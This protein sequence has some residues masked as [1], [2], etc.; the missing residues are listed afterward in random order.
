[1]T[2]GSTAIWVKS[3]VIVATVLILV[4]LALRQITASKDTSL[5]NAP[6]ALGSSSSRI[7][8]SR[9]SG[10][11]AKAVANAA[12]SI[13]LSWYSPAQTE[14]NNL[15][16]VINGTGVWGFI[17]NTSDT[18]VEKYGQYNWCHMPHVRKTE[19]VKLP[20]EYELKYVEL[21][22]RHHKRT[23]YAKNSFPVESYKWDCDD[24][25]NFYYEEFS[26][27]RNKPGKM[28]WKVY[29]SPANPFVPA[30]FLGTCHF[31]QITAQGLDDSWLHGADLYGVY[32]DVLGFL[33]A[34]DTVNSAEWHSKVKYRVTKNP[35]TSH[36]AGM[37]VNG[38]WATT[39][40]VP[41]II[42][43]PGVDSLE[44]EYPC[45][46]G[47]DLHFGIKSPSNPVWAQHLAAADPLYTI[48]DDI[49]GFP[50][51]DEVVHTLMDCYYDNLSARQCH[52]K[53]LP[54]KLVDGVNST[55]CVT[56]DVAD[57]VY[58]LGHWEYSELYRGSR[59][60]FVSNIARFGVWLAELAAHLRA[61]VNGE[62]E[63]L[64]FHNV[65]NDCSV[66]SILSILQVDHMVWPGMGAEVLFELYEK[67]SKAGDPRAPDAGAEESGWYVRV[68]W[69]GQVLKSSSPQFG[70]MNMV[71]VEKLLAYLD[72]LVGENASLI[73][74]KCDN[75]VATGL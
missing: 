4:Q 70:I 30:G 68:L 32:H 48:L 37:V 47:N 3:F 56:Q 39:D 22:H 18:P 65:A 53:P 36:V 46:L 71:P 16:A 7:G 9:N 19:Y 34:R 45:R 41:L 67:R 61:V 12:T 69:G 75:R 64:Y 2:P 1:M 51:D 50:A 58:R 43:V 8:E 10:G 25:G 63:T 54:C 27:S 28:Y 35:I 5:L 49:S 13:D 6:P 17:Y 23:P 26:N 21:V 20:D 66:S 52:D 55:I 59:D 24:R 60:S 29:A 57:A 62:S 42:Q 33:P 72:G 31:P 40:P 73:K 15:D 74:G 38:M 11:L 14:I 44:P